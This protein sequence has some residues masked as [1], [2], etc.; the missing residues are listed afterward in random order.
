M[1]NSPSSSILEYDLFIFDLDGT[2]MDTEDYHLFAWEAAI[3]EKTKKSDFE[4]TIQDYHT[5]FHSLEPLNMKNYLKITHSLSNFDDVYECK[6]MYYKEYIRSEDISFMKGAYDFLEYILQNNK[7]FVIVTNTRKD[8]MNIFLSKHPILNQALEICTKE[9]FIR[10]K[11]YPDCYLYIA[12][13][14][15]DKL[16][17]GFEDSYIGITA[18][19]QVPDIVPILIY[20]KNYGYNDIIQKI[21]KNVFFLD[22]YNR[23]QLELFLK[24]RKY[25]YDLYEEEYEIES[26]LTK[27]IEQLQ[28]HF[29]SMKYIIHHVST[30]VKNIG[31]NHIYL[32]G[33][34]KSGY[35]C[36][37][38]ASTWQSLS[39]K[40]SYI[41]LHNL[42]H[43]DLGV[44]E[45]NDIIIFISNSGNTEECV[46]VIKY[47]K[48]NLDKKVITISIV[49]NQNC[50][51]EKYSHF[52]YVLDTINEADF[53]N[54][55][56][57]SSSILFMNLL[58]SIA[59][60]SKKDI[61]K[62]EFQRNHPSGS[63]G[64]K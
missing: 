28:T 31:L 53:I 60:Y 35:V 2:L 22:K 27:N 10:N 11:P 55:T 50:E 62:E 17:I 51:M 63:I 34:G 12:N 43:G 30:F 3:Q 44:L 37:K 36:K 49:A 64:K 38:C 18:L 61:T 24:D 5:Y 9:N 56:P 7:Q 48:T 45:N 20:N 21:Y 6:Q 46:N 26:I 47:I 14:Y 42:M 19:N 23:Y 15:K 40:C 8:F 52:T 32:T 59:I 57:S 1:G 58:D 13:K 29:Y 54:M 41:D 4:L 16:K 39:I 33:M 25:E